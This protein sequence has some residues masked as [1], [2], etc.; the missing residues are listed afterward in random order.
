MIFS[1]PRITR[2]AVLCGVILSLGLLPACASKPPVSTVQNAQAVAEEEQKTRKMNEVILKSSVARLNSTGDYVI[3][4]ED[5]LELDV[6]STE[7]FK[8]KIFRVNS[9]GFIGLPLVGKVKAQGFTAAQLEEEVARQLERY[10]QRP[11]ATVSVKEFKSQRIAVMGAVSKP[12]VFTV[13]GPKYLLDMLFSAGGLKDA[14]KGC[15]IFR[16]VKQENLEVAETE[17]IIIDL[18]ELLEK[19]NRSLNIPVF[20]G[21]IINIPKGGVIYVDGAVSKRGMYPLAGRTTLLMAIAMAGGTR[22]VADNSDIVVLRDT[23]QG[24]RQVLRA[25]YESAKYDTK[26]DIRIQDNDIIIV[27]RSGWKTFVDV[28]GTFFWGGVT[29]DAS[30]KLTPYGGFGRGSVGGTGVTGTAPWQQQ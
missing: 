24:I 5:V 9:Q 27:G 30:G 4:P 11:I 21:D 7:E 17:T 20:S 18:E 13:T 6:L 2:I 3:G 22:F 25:D 1:L 23:G 10:L 14:G 28:M 19:G 16:P 29:V 12:D 8:G 26:A 15:Y